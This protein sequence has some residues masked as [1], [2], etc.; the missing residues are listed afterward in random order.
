MALDDETRLSYLDGS[1]VI[2]ILDADS[3]RN[4]AAR[5]AI[6]QAE[7]RVPCISDLVRLEI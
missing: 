6:L 2:D 4:P 1:F 3:A 5:T 7:E